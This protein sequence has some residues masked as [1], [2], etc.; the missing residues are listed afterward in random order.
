V[1]G[2]LVAIDHPTPCDGLGL[3]LERRYAAAAATFQGAA[4]VVASPDVAAPCARWLHPDPRALRD[5]LC[6][7][8]YPT[9]PQ[10]DP[11]DPS[12]SIHPSAVI[13]PYTVIGAGCV[14]EAGCV[15]G[16]HAVLGPRVYVGPGCVV[17]A[18]AA[19]GQP[20]FGLE[21]TPDGLTRR[22][23]HIG[24]V[25]LAADV[26]VG[27]HTC[28][29]AG[30]LSP[31][32]IG[33]GSRIDNLVH[34]AHNVR[35]GRGCILLAQVGVAGSVTLEDGCVLAGQAGIAGHLRL[36]HHAQVAAQA[37]VGHSA[38]PHARLGGSPAFDLRRWQRASLLLQTLDQRL[39]DLERRIQP[40]NDD[41]PPDRD[42]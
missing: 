17:G 20:G 28:I 4:L 33:A 8:F 18:H 32:F 26:Q 16:P 2:R 3:L 35:I 30:T 37:G 11:I 34:I 7:R 42:H 6:A 41:H 10:R 39:R 23:P 21:P 13:G 9:S 12:A 36:G 1:I 5:A 14:I 27:A 38:P 31:T 40:P 29:D 25:F 24:G 22:L 15:I 19:L